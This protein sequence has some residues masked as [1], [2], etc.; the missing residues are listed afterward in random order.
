MLCGLLGILC[1]QVDAFYYPNRADLTQHVEVLDVGSVEECRRIVYQLALENNDPDMV[2]GD[3]E[4]G[5][6]PSNETF[7]GIRV[8]E[9]TVR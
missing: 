8:Y 9:E 2:R 7:G 4:C 3:Y 6:N 5:V 1:P